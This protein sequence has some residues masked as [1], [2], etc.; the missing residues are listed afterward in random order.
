MERV[1]PG[2][3]A[4]RVRAWA[5]AEGGVLWLC[6]QPGLADPEWMP[7]TERRATQ[8]N[9]RHR[10]TRHGP[11]APKHAEAVRT[12]ALTADLTPFPAPQHALTASR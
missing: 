12:R 7:A 5:S 6:A 4:S 8:A 3:V 9:R 11:G 1:C 10:P 2:F